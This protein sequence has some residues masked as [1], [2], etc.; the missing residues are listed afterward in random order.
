[1][2]ALPIAKSYWEGASFLHKQSMLALL[3]FAAGDAY[4]F[5]CEFA[6]TKIDS[7][8]LSIETK[9]GFL[10]G[11]VSDD[12]LLT[13]LTILA[14]QED[15]P[16][17]AGD[18]FLELLRTQVHNLRGLGPTTRS[19]LGI[20]IKDEEIAQIGISNGGMMRTAICGIAFDDSRVRRDWI[21]AL[22]APTHSMSVARD[23]AIGLAEAYANH[24]VSIREAVMSQKLDPIVL[25]SVAN[26]DSW[27]PPKN[28]ISNDALETLLAVIYVNERA[29]SLLDVYHRAVLLGGD[30]DTVAAL[31]SGLY[32]VRNSDPFEFLSLPWI[33]QVDW[34]DLGDIERLID[35]L[36]LRRS[37]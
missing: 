27:I 20:Q 33:H 32:A 29:I 17:Q 21:S 26:I 5:Q 11:A 13:R 16:S 23:C 35:I 12:T 34:S 3:S 28:G 4:G 37:K 2:S 24:G 15:S 25:K 22:A 36:L 9:P 8:P 1:M 10:Q 30:T 18:K 14:L 31:S 6:K 19:A 7:A